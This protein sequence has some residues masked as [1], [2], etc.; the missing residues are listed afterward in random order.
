MGSEPIPRRSS[1]WAW[2][3]SLGVDRAASVKVNTQFPTEA[4]A[5][6]S[7]GPRRG[8]TAGHGRP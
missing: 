6:L 7:A 3:T 1:A 2:P 8:Q 5:S 4:A